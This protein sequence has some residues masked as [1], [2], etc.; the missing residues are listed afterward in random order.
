MPKYQREAAEF[1]KDGIVVIRQIMPRKIIGECLEAMK[2][3]KDFEIPLQ[4]GDAVFDEKNGERQLKYFQHLQLYIPAF[5]KLYNSRL[6]EVAREFFDQDVYFS[7]MGL[8]DKA[9]KFGTFTPMHQDNFYSCLKPPYFVTAYVPLESQSRENGGMMYLKGSHLE[10][11]IPH[12]KGL[13]KA[14]SSAIS[15]KEFR[16]EDFYRPELEPGDVAFHHA[17]MIHGAEINNSNRHRRAVAVG[18]FGELAG[19]DEELKA[20]YEKNRQFNRVQ[21]QQ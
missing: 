21:P 2:S 7:P 13:V 11:V 10:G 20:Q 1:H 12:E 9:P 3:F 16:S 8:H 19:I 5:L 4:R 6:L 15:G 14:F 18:I 17:N